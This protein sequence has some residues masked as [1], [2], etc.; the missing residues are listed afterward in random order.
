MGAL[1][2]QSQRIIALAVIPAR[3]AQACGPFARQ[4]MALI[5]AAQGQQTGIAG[6][7]VPRKNGADELM[8][9]EGE[10]ELW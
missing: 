1:P 5:E 9:A 8:M 10:A 7:L 4:T 2:Q 3:I 6:D